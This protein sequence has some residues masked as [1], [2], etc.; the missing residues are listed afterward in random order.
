M[1]SRFHSTPIQVRTPSQLPSPL[2]V[3]V[4]LLTLPRFQL[5]NNVIMVKFYAA[6]FS[7]DY[8]FP[9]VALAY[10]LRYPNPYSTHVLSTDV[11]E[12]SFDPETGRLCTTRLHLKRSKIPPTVLKL[13]PR[14]ILGAGS[15]GSSTQSYILEKSTIDINEGWME[16][17]SRNLEWTGVLSVIEKQIYRRR[18]PSLGEGLVSKL[19]TRNTEAQSEHT[20]VDSTV[21]LKSRLGEAKRKKKRKEAA[22]RAAVATAEDTEDET[23]K[24]SVWKAWS[25][26]PV[27]R[28]I[29]LIAFRRT[30]GSQP[31]AKEGMK[32]VLE[33][34]RQ[35]GIVAVLDG[36]HKD[37]L[38][39]G[40]GSHGP[41]KEQLSQGTGTSV[42]VQ[43]EGDGFLDR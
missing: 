14:S 12:R 3:N 32:V 36:M 11:I 34:L 28:S 1:T 40:R 9:A 30:E 23:Q 17:E 15:N 8:S 24:S 35:G 6:S 27:Q 41:W 29:E 25:T 26:G 5:Y 10:F 18:A 33:R 39:S 4:P 22:D 16:S 7:Y 19:A 42:T 43:H 31:K 38:E 21:T 37:H 13:L 20:D 2:S